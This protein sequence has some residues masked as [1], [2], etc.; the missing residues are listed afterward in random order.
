VPSVWKVV[1]WIYLTDVVVFAAKFLAGLFHLFRKIITASAG[2]RIIEIDHPALM[3]FSFFNF[4]FMSRAFDLSSADRDYII[5]REK[6]H[7]RKL[8]SVD[9]PLIEILRIVFWFNPLLVLYK[10]EI[11]LVHEFEADAVLS[12]E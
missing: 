12:R 9:I 3:A 8:H 4:I 7:G 5:Q 2:K 10:K 1:F 11:I 6:V